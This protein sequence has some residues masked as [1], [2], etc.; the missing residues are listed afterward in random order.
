MILKHHCW[1]TKIYE[2]KGKWKP[3]VEQQLVCDNMV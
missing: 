1:S 2:A 3:D